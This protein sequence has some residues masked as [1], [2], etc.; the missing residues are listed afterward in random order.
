MS[1]QEAKKE[2]IRQAV[3]ELE[4]VD[5]AARCACLGLSAPDR[6]NVYLRAFGMDLILQ[7][8]DFQLIKADTGSPAKLNDHILVLHYLL[9]DSPILATDELISFR[10]L[11]GGQFYWQPFLLCIVRPLVG[12]IGNALD[13]LCKNLQRFDWEPV[14]MDDFGAR[15]HVI[16]KLYVTLVYHCGD[17]GFPAT[18]D[19][20]FNACI[21]RVFA[22]K[23]AAVL[24]SRICFGLL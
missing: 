6:G 4:H 14:V 23:D 22:A 11:P 5:L 2:A 17:N 15:I 21:K 16:G 12:R 10:G 7:Q 19:L 8:A 13:L 9:C 1:F 20:L 24:A 3:A 18:A